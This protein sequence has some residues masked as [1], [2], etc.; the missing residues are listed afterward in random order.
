MNIAILRY[1][2]LVTAWKGKRTETEAA[3]VLGVAPNTLGNWTDGHSL[4][5]ST[6]IP[7][8][9]TALG[10]PVDDLRALVE[11]DRKARRRSLRTRPSRHP[12]NP[13]AKGA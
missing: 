12:H 3:A 9:A 7:A 6:K 5:P 2:R 8:L 1:S 11:K 10:M 4:P 13:N